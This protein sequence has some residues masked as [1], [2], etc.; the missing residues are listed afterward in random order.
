MSKA[1]VPVDEFVRMWGETGSPQELANR[2]GIS[3]R[4]VLS[5]RRRIESSQGIKLAS[6]VNRSGA[7]Y[8]HL[9]GVRERAEKRITVENGSVVV[10]S[11]AHF[12]PGVRTTA[13]RGLLR[14]IEEIKP[15]CVVNNGDAFDGAGISRHPRI[16]WQHSPTVQD[17]LKACDDALGEIQERAGKAK[18]FWPLGNHDARF[19]TFLAANVPQFEGVQGFRLH[20]KFP[21]WGTCWSLWVNDKTVIK[22]RWK[23]GIHASHNNTV[24]AGVTMV[25]GHLH[26]LKVTP[27]DD[28]NGTRWGVDTGTLADV[29][30]P[31]FVD[32]TEANPTNWRSGF[33]VLT[34]KDGRLMW[35]EIARVWDFDHLEWRGRILD[36]SQE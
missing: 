31:Q 2:L 13:F 1:T 7:Y 33:V 9:E 23:S 36:V 19:E 14:V 20:D 22:H 8:Q 27:F 25:T 29:R 6:V 32:Y 28:F 21:A 17:E 35:P 11:D 4:N 18:L 15:V 3:V 16:G 34:F 10:F 24:N 26:S 5:R 30:G 12:W